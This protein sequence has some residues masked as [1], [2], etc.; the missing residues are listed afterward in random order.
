MICP[1]LTFSEVHAD[2]LLQVVV[3][4]FRKWRAFDRNPVG[5]LLVASHCA[6]RSWLRLCHD[7]GACAFKIMTLGTCDAVAMSWLLS[8]C[9]LTRSEEGIGEM[10][11]HYCYA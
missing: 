9:A 3:S 7:G 4:S 10:L 5:G 2:T 8:G 6:L 11:Q 1:V